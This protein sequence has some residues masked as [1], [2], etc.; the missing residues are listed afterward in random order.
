MKDFK[1]HTT[2]VFIIIT[3]L[4]LYGIIC[5]RYDWMQIMALSF[6]VYWLIVIANALFNGNEISVKNE[7]YRPFVSILI[8]ARNEE[9]VIAKTVL[10]LSRIKYFKKGDKH[11]EIIVIDDGSTDLTGKILKDLMGSV[12]ELKIVTIPEDE[13]GKGKSRALNIALEHAQGEIIAVFDA[14]SRVDEFFLKDA[15]S[16][17][18]DDR[19]AGVQARVR[20]YN[21]GENMVSGFQEDEFAVYSHLLQT[22]RQAIGGMTSLGGN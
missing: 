8:P 14:D 12:N 15:V 6:S 1:K 13:S 22:G 3:V 2:I 16:Y 9:N 20:I 11:F 4:F 18:Y 10:S 17:L 19:V 5:K 7:F 21:A